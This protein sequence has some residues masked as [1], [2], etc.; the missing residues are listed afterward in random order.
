[1]RF[2]LL[3]FLGTSDGFG[4]ASTN[5]VPAPRHF[6]FNQNPELAFLLGNPYSEFA[7]KH[8]K[9]VTLF[10]EH[11]IVEP[12]PP[13]N[14]RVESKCG[15]IVILELKNSGSGSG[16]PIL[17]P[18]MKPVKIPVIEGTPACPFDLR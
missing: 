8:P 12:S 2:C 17:P 5:A 7:V 6:N 16:I 1:M 4:Q 13:A 14:K 11:K 10:A 3:L 15:H 18:S 9:P